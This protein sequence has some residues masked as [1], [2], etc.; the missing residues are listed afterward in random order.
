[1]NAILNT[2]GDAMW[3]T[4]SFLP[5]VLAI[6]VLSVLIAAGSLFV[7]KWTSNQ[8]KIRRA[9]GPMKAHLLGIFL[10]RHDLRLVFRSLFSALGTSLANLRFLAVPMAVM[11]VPLIVI[12]VQLELRLGA[13]GLAPEAT[14]VLR[15]HL[16]PGADLSAVALEAPSGLVVD[17]PGVRVSD[18]VRGLRE[19]DFRLKGAEA[20]RYDLTVASASG[21]V[22]KEVAVG[23]VAGVISPVRETAGIGAVL[24]AP[25][26]AAL[27]ADGDV[28][29][30]ELAYDAAVYPFLGID[31]AWWVLFLV[32]MVLALFA[33][34]GPLGVDF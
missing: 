1:M 30:I 27:P 9:K 7:F 3:A 10:F 12:F 24:F 21:A 18:P 17:S 32:F 28:V 8:E 14:T 15:V 4:V 33:L 25:G 2:I 13:T 20:G 11:I 6:F 26:E 31:W 16:R 19:V 23:P 29:K 22:T 34:R 5:P